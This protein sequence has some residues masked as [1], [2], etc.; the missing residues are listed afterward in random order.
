MKK[1]KI[2]YN[3]DYAINEVI[4]DRIG[5]CYRNTKLKRTIQTEVN[6]RELLQIL[7]TPNTSTFKVGI[8][9]R[10]MSIVEL[11]QNKELTIKVKRGMK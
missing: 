2:V 11:K 1:L 7:N 4:T 9:G 6:E 8:D 10:L 3:G 5:L